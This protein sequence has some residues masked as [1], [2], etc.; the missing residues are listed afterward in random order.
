MIKGTH[1]VLKREYIL[2]CAHYDHL[3]IKRNCDDRD[4]IYNGARD[5]GMGIV[6]LISAAKVLSNNPTAR[7]VVFV[8]FTGEEE[9]MCGSKYFIKHPPLNLNDIKFVLNNDGGG[10]NDTAVV[11]VAGLD[12]TTGKESIIK[13]CASA[14]LGCLPYPAELQYLCLLSDNAPFA[15]IGIPSVTMSPGF[16]KVDEDILKYVHT[17]ADEADDHFDYFYLRKFAEAY[18]LAAI[19]MANSNTHLELR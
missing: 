11:R 8:A 15:K 3:G 7:S 6:S 5:N 13:A 12:K 16:D 4:T 18:T 19:A 9:G 2:L 17:V 10:Y 1:P 14:H